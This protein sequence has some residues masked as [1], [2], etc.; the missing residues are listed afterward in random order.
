MSTSND[1]YLTNIHRSICNISHKKIIEETDTRILT[2]AYNGHG[3]LIMPDV[4]LTS[5][6]VISGSDDMTITNID[7]KIAKLVGKSPVNKVNRKLDIAIFEIDR[8]LTG[9]PALFASNEDV[10][11]KGGGFVMSNFGRKLEFIAAKVD[12]LSNVFNRR[13]AFNRQNFEL[14]GRVY[15]GYSGSP[16][17]DKQGRIVSVVTDAV[18]R[19]SRSKGCANEEIDSKGS[20]ICQGPVAQ[21]VAKMIRSALKAYM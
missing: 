6:H 18:Y 16:V 20:N 7:G 10:F 19:N 13:V 17:F 14:D 4:V 3:V 1:P 8:P 9:H 12:R 5:W 11:K 21:P 15:P 2:N